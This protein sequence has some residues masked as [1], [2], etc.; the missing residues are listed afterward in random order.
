[1]SRSSFLSFP[2]RDRTIES[3]ACW[4]P[5]PRR[6]CRRRFFAPARQMENLDRGLVAVRASSTQA[7]LSGVCLASIPRTSASTSI[8]RPTAAPVKLNA[9]PLTGG[10]N[11]ASNRRRPNPLNF[12]VSNAYFVRADQ[13]RRA[14]GGQHRHA[15]RQH[16]GRAV[17]DRPAASPT[18]RHDAAE[19]RPPE[20][21]ELHL[22]HND[23][24]VAISTVTGTTSTSSSG[25][26]RM[27]RTTRRTA[28]PATSTSTPTRP[29]ARA[30]GA[31]T[32]ASTSARRAYTQFM[33]Y[34]P[35]R[36]RR[37]GRDED[38]ARHEGRH[39]ANVIL[40]GHDL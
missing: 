39:A 29:T 16:A 23:M 34:D 20:R 26:R 2:A 33:A 22:Q 35:R 40:P 1:M 10:T 5:L 27:R 24:S 7:F 38:R 31:S 6:A 12:A 32:S 15:R 14:A 19:P 13:R 30:S 11:Y 9:S 17:P 18:A 3:A 8:A 36:R 4:R 21:R 28:S 25:I 37:R